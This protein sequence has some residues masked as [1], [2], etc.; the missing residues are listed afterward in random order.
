MN[1]KTAR[2]SGLRQRL[3]VTFCPHRDK[4]RGTITTVFGRVAFG[5]S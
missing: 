2:A 5:Y 3:L 1:A 4:R